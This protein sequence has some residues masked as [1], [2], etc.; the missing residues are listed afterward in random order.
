MPTS[1]IIP[2]R[3]EKFLYQT[4]LECLN[5]SNGEIEVLV[6]LDGCDIPENEK[7]KDSRV[8]YILRPQTYDLQKRQAINEAVEISK[9]DH[10][11]SLDAH[12]MLGE[13]FDEILERDC[14]EN[15]VLVPRRESLDAKNWKIYRPEGRPP[16]DYEYFIWQFFVKGING[17]P[18]GG[19]HG[20][21]WD[22]RSRERKDIMIDEIQTFQGSSWFT[23]K[24]WFRKCG[25][26]DIEGYTG[27][28]GESNQISLKTLINGGKVMI[29]K[30]VWYAHLHKGRAY[31]RMYKV[32][33]GG[34]HAADF[35][36]F[37]QFVNKNRKIFVELVERF[38]PIPNWKENWKELLPKI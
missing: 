21:R 32:K 7:I 27:W 34:I 33:E 14:Q 31:G 37:D 10:V 3:S 18:K 2:S 12:C 17:E 22:E 23:H 24:A 25:L 35:Y 5:K 20:Y 29:D 16:I 6:M 28:G 11:M 38:W 36:S 4:T 30:N 26:M 1:I 9:Y 8:K 15:W 19:L 13:G